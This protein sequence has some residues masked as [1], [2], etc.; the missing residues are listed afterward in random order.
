MYF[1]RVPVDENGR[2][3]F[4]PDT[5]Q[6]PAEEE[7]GIFPQNSLIHRELINQT[8]AGRAKDE[9]EEMM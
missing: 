2:S 8:L 3:E 1:Q 7:L 4:I 5:K 9:S 6:G